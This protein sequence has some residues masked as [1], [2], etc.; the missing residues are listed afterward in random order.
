MRV[1]TYLLSGRLIAAPMAGVTDRPFRSLCRKLGAAFAVSEMVSSNPALR[2]TRKTR[3]RTSHAGEAEPRWVQI[4]GAD[5]AEMAQAARENEARGAQIIDVNMGCPAKKV[6]NRS[7]GS[8]LLSDEGLVARI[9][10]AV[11]AAV[12]VPVTLKIRTGPD[13]SN[14]NAPR[15]AAL[16]EAAGVQALSVHGRTRACGFSGIAEHATVR[17][18]RSA[19]RI[20][21]IANGDIDSPARAA[22]VLAESGADALMIGR[23]AQGNPWIFRETAHYLATGERLAAP[24]PE[25]VRDTLLAHLDALYAHYGEYQGVRIARKHLGWYLKARPGGDRHWALIRRVETAEA[26]TRLARGFFD[27]P[28]HALERAA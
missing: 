15:I 7:A 18:V 16:A 8:A 12:S 24:P 21:V 22:T 26:Q 27:A 28:Q 23:A 2:K 11:V 17:A 4:V 5:P 25:E 1:G 13:P 6:C 20:P 9:L 3:Q 19:V 10:D 14:R